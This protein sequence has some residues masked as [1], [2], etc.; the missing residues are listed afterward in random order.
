MR[1][2][3]RVLLI[4]LFALFLR[5]LAAGQ[6][7]SPTVVVRP[8]STASD[9]GVPSVKITADKERVPLGTLVQFSMSPASLASDRR[10]VVTL[11]FGDGQR[12]VMHQAEA[13]HFYS[14]VGTYT[15]S[16]AVK[17]SQLSDPKL[18]FSAS[19]TPAREGELVQ[20][21]AR[22]SSAD[23]ALQYRFVYGDGSPSIWQSSANAQHSYA[24]AGNYFAYVDVGDGKQ[25][26]A[27][28][29]RKQITIRPPQPLQVSLVASPLPARNGQ[30]VVFN[31]RVSPA[32]PNTK[33]Q[34][35][36]GDGT[37][38]LWQVNP[39]AQHIYNSPGSHNAFVRVSQSA[40]N[41]N[42]INSNV[43]AVNVQAIQ[44]SPS[45]PG[46]GPNTYP[47]PTPTTPDPSTSPTPSSSPTA[48]PASSVIDSATT[49]SGSASP[50]TPATTNVDGTNP[51]VLPGAI[52]WWY[53]LLLGLL[54]LGLFKATAY[55]FTA[56]PMFA[57]VSDPGVAAIT[58]K[59]G[60]LPLEF[61]LVL[62]PN[63]STGD[64][65][66]TSNDPQLIKNLDRLQDRQVLEI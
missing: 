14:A 59:K 7:A 27:G 56:K 46:S 63:V 23:P 29:A 36:F 38:T 2:Q 40:N 55:L 41:P 10:Y 61:Q 66:V 22:L 43:V 39:Q 1:L 15:Y 6:Q 18:I 11:L 13:T 19:P 49:I 12:Q 8:G 32:T 58:N 50:E 24:R 9:Q 34:F 5:A 26:L 47:T 3:P 52:R 31:A 28:S 60:L 53:W 33:Y 35:N 62:S 21:T 20:F 16:V 30:L 37:P 48:S 45:D 57:A 54:L 64:Y 42:A 65:S 51:N 17:R 25:A 4:I 44:T